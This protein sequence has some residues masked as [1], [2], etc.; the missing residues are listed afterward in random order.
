MR[1]N[2]KNLRP[3][4]LDDASSRSWESF[5]PVSTLLLISSGSVPHGLVLVFSI[6]RSAWISVSCIIGLLWGSREVVAMA[7]LGQVTCMGEWPL[8]PGVVPDSWS[9]LQWRV[10]TGVFEGLN[11]FCGS[12]LQQPSHYIIYLFSCSSVTENQLKWSALLW[13]GL[14]FCGYFR[15]PPLHLLNFFSC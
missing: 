3:N 8:H 5:M 2:G 7:G 9:F 10:A 14:F 4:L 6:V 13:N 12:C 15:A 11:L 1:C